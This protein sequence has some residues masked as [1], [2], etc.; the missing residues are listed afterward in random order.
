MLHRQ[1][2]FDFYQLTSSGDRKRNQDYMAHII[3]DDYALFVVA[4]GLGGHLA[5]ERAS[6]YFCKGL[7]QHAPRYAKIISRDPEVI[8]SAWIDTAIDEMSRLFAGDRVAGEAHT[9][10]AVLFIQDDLVVT[11]HC[12][13]S[14]IY[15]LNL[16]EILWRT[17]DHSVTQMLFD[18]G[19]VSEREMGVHPGQNQ[20]TRSINVLRPHEPE[21]RVHSAMTPGETFILCTDGFWEYTKPNELLNLAQKD[22][23][24]A[25]L[26]KQ[27]KLS[28]LRAQGKSDN[29]TVQWVRAV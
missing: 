25:D 9:T 24:R 20:L 8:F 2:K 5:G 17:R 18:E 11:V 26:I 3:N 16:A 28:Y 13:D 14:R 23:N 19:E 21:I 7:I 10:C 12:G 15:R 1:M 4:D 6:G 27:A 29:L 22:S